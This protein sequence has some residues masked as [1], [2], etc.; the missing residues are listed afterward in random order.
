MGRPPGFFPLRPEIVLAY[1][2]AVVLTAMKI[3]DMRFNIGGNFISYDKHYVLYTSRLCVT[4]GVIK[5]GFTVGPYFRQLLCT[6]EA[7]T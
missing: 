3:L 1:K 4:D 5:D 6:S 2:C 7:A